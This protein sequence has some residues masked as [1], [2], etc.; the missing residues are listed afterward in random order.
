MIPHLYSPQD[1]SLEERVRAYRSVVQAQRNIESSLKLA[2]DREW[3]DRLGT[4]DELRAAKEVVENSLSV[5]VSAIN[6]DEIEKS[7]SDGLI[8]QDDAESLRLV[9]QVVSRSADYKERVMERR[10][11]EIEKVRARKL[12]GDNNTNRNRFR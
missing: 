7:V 3:S 5:A 8:S 10:T 12:D 4:E 11:Q 1:D 6:A 9:K 2:A